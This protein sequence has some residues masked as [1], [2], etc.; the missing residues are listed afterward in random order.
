MK[1]SKSN[2][3][4]QISKT[5]TNNKKDKMKRCPMCEQMFKGKYDVVCPACQWDERS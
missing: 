4:K 5:N 1:I 2:K 3:V